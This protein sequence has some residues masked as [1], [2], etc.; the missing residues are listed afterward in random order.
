M[1]S[2]WTKYIKDPDTKAQYERSLKNSKW[3][4]DDLQTILTEM[5]MDLE[6]GELSPKAYDIPNWS[7]KQAHCNGSKQI[8]NIILRIINLDQ[9]ETNGTPT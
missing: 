7:W 2:A 9:K 6:K 4:L 1:Y 3:V 8:I 5:K